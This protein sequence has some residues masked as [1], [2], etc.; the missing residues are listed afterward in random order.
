[1]QAT[2]FIIRRVLLLIVVL[3][4]V[5]VLTFAIVNVLPGDVATAVLGDMATP[6]QVT[7][8]RAALGLDQP[9]AQRYLHWLLGVLH[10]DFGNSLQHGMPIGPMLMGRLGNSAILGLITLAIAAPLAVALGVVAALKPNGVLDR[11]IGA[12]AVG[13]YALP[14]YVIGLLCILTFSIWLPLLPG[15]SL[16]DPNENPLS[17]PEALILPIGVLITGMLAFISQ[18]TRASMIQ[19][20]ASAY[21]RTAILKGVP[22]WRV[23]TKHALPNLLPPTIAEI[24][25]YFGYVIGGLV[26]VETLF[27]YAGLGQLVTNAVSY[28]DVPVIQAVVLLVAAAYGIG[29]LIADV[30]ALLL[31]PRLRA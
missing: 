20:M 27:S 19:V 9:L 22:R 14:E 7:A 6:D 12:I 18:I 3:L 13:A 23:V 2:G 17:R 10:G 11:V 4:A 30:A 16:M 26:V 15:S 8:V 31:N 24:G 1:M 29:N 5:S 25:M 21:V 28:R